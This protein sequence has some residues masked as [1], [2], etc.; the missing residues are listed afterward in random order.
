MDYASVEED[1]DLHTA[2]ASL[3]ANAADP[4][5]ARVPSAFAEILRQLSPCD[6]RLLDGIC[7]HILTTEVLPIQ[8]EHA[9][10]CDLIR[11]H[12]LPDRKIFRV[13]DMIGY[14][15]S[16]NEPLSCA[17]AETELGPQRRE[18]KEQCDIALDNLMRLR[19][20]ES[21]KEIS[22]PMPTIQDINEGTQYTGQRVK[23]D[24]EEL[25][26][27]TAFGFHFIEICTKPSDRREHRIYPLAGKRP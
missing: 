14:S 5:V 11:S 18:S 13:W 4:G 17:E 21:R 7:R 22:I 6:D 26:Y 2:W 27:V 3:L 8:L 24:T 16:G 9:S 12:G 25:F 20:V 15:P 10:Q 1:D 19:L 23:H